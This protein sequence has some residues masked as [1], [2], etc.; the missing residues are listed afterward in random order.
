MQV[1]AAYEASTAT[2]R[3]VLAHPSLQLSHVDETV[4]SLSEAMAD[5]AEIDYAIQSGGKEAVRAGGVINVDEGDLEKELDDLVLQE[6]EEREERGKARAAA[7]PA[8][9]S[10][11]EADRPAV[12]GATNVEARQDTG[13]NVPVPSRPAS[14][15][16]PKTPTTERDQ[17][18]ID[19][20]AQLRK[21]E[22]AARALAERLKKEEKRLAL[23]SEE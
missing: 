7:S 9:V 1:M 23:A 2:L 18:A 15:A 3:S 12:Q 11:V 5:Q 19:D 10:P 8:V 22:E 13:Q 16:G 4:S 6:K 14:V 21:G 20:A 17:S